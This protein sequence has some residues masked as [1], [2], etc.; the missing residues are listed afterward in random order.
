MSKS[1]NE[2]SLISSKFE[3]KTVN[4]PVKSKKNSEGFYEEVVN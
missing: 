1:K 3:S 4:T 2:R